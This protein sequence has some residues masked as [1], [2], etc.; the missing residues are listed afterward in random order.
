MGIHGDLSPDVCS[1][2]LE[3]EVLEI[4][5]RIAAAGKGHRAS[6]F[7]V[8]WWS[9]KLLAWAMSN[10]SFKTQLFRFVDVYPACNGDDDVM[11]IGR[12]TW[13]RKEMKRARAT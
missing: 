8:S 4:G 10:P 2:D 5:R 12:A 13:R 9:D 3:R 6:L 7:R 11:Q 1:T